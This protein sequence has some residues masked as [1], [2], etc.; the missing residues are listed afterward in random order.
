MRSWVASVAVVTLDVCRGGRNAANIL[1]CLI[2]AAC[3][4][5]AAPPPSEGVA[6]ATEAVSPSDSDESER[7]AGYYYPPVTSRESYESRAR[8]LQGADRD[9]RIGFV[10]AITRQQFTF[11][12]S[13]QYT[14]YAKGDEA[15]KLIIVALGE[16]R[17]ATI[18]QAR[19]L[20][21][22]LTAVARASAFFS[23]LGVESYFTF[24]DLAKMLGFERLT[25]SDGERFTHRV[26]IF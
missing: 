8:T 22:Q 24:F 9:R 23:E 25:I 7:H 14:M 20:L 11:G 6:A 19:A 4:P 17:I 18:Y 13:P 3:A 1:I 21:A 5:V 10:T 16:G 15:E 2:V 26:E 12:Y